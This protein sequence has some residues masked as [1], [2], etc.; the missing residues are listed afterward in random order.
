MGPVQTD[1]WEWIDLPL[2]HT[3]S[4][5][6]VVDAMASVLRPFVE[7]YGGPEWVEFFEDEGRRVFTRGKD[8]YVS[9]GYRIG[10]RRR[11]EPRPIVG[12]PVEVSA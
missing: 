6:T 4:K 3:S 9:T 11:A 7:K 12:N 10:V 8:G 2:H 1:E 5:Q